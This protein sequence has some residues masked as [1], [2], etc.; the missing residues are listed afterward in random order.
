MT[1]FTFDAALPLTC[2]QQ[3][4]AV[5]DRVATAG[6]GEVTL[7][8][9]RYTLG[10]VELRSGV[11]LH[12]GAGCEVVVSTERA[13]YAD[14]LWYAG[15]PNPVDYLQA[16]FFARD[17][18]D[19]SITGAGT[20]FGEDKAFWEPLER[21]SFA[22]E[23]IHYRKKGWRPMMVA[24]ERCRRFRLEGVRF[25]ASPAYALWLIACDD[26][27]VRD[28][29]VDHD[30]HGPNTDGFHLSSCQRVTISGCHFVTGDDAI[31]IDGDGTRPA[32]DISISNCL[33]ETITNAV[34]LYTGLD[35]WVKEPVPGVVERVSINHCVVRN[36]SCWLNVVA[37][38]GE[39]RGVVA[40]GIVGRQALP[41]TALF[42][43]TRRGTIRDVAVSDWVYEGNGVATFIADQP[44]AIAD[45]ALCRSRFRITP[46][47]KEWA[48]ALPQGEQGYT[49]YHG[50]PWMIHLEETR[51]VT[52]RELEVIWQGQE[53]MPPVLV[54][55]AAGAAA[56]A[57]GGCE[58]KTRRE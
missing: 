32:S 37:W 23:A 52:L 38:D 40:Q 39:I 6:G 11:H 28:V 57:Q 4:Q 12:L 9:G 45:V 7:P 48:T 26:V 36:A 15:T 27:T 47:P 34:R 49:V 42:M 33:F 3:L 54:T 22:P 13:D 19:L 55:G 44:G 20:I 29:Q 21:E 50:A 51:E 56:L 2:T 24:L 18:E 8:A 5:I 35:P 31:A 17:A 1:L 58:I 41:G 43:Q 14:Q 30:F 10:S 53:A 16:L 25:V 46:Y